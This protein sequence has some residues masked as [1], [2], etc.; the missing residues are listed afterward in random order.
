MADTN[1]YTSKQN[2]KKYTTQA[3]FDAMDKSD[4]PVGTEYNIVGEIEE[5]DLS[6]ELQTK[7]ASITGKQDVITNQTSLNAA[8]LSV[9]ALTVGTSG[10][11]V[12]GPLTVNGYS[13]LN[14]IFVDNSTTNPICFKRNN[15]IVTKMY[16]PTSG[17]GELVNVYLPGKAGTLA[18]TDDLT[19]KQDKLTMG[20]GL[21]I[22]GNV[23]YCNGSLTGVLLDVNNIK[24]SGQLDMSGTMVR[25][26]LTYNFPT[27][28]GTFALTSDI[29]TGS[30]GT[31]ITADGVVKTAMNASSTGGTG[32]LLMTDEYGETHCSTVYADVSG[33]HVAIT[34]AEKKTYSTELY[35][36]SICFSYDSAGY[37]IE[38]GH[39]VHLKGPSG[40]SWPLHADIY[41]PA[42]SGTVALLSDITGG[43][44]SAGVSSIDGKTGAILLGTGLT[45]GSNNVLSVTQTTNNARMYL[46]RIVG[47]F[48]RNDGSYKIM[49]SVY[50]G[51][52]TEFTGD[53]LN[54]LIQQLF[55]YQY[56]SVV[57]AKTDGS[58]PTGWDPTKFEQLYVG[59]IVDDVLYCNFN[60]MSMS[61]IQLYDI[62]FEM[63]IMEEIALPVS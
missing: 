31:T 55:E 38:D 4:V 32:V 40:G 60:E 50:N 25:G 36:D 8:A 16:G 57:I 2:I 42:K 56:T 63:D 11:T 45:I 35:P 53:T 49:I 12:S 26:G 39:Y 13:S 3:K 24:I 37:P 29:P 33:E 62:P 52:D 1:T 20:A 28:G 22:T 44:G 18:V 17:G 6:V 34:S 48:D 23:I 47:Y 54:N 9:N 27:K 43:G 21:S 58:S 59:T 19:G 7:I 30:G 46:H 10:A 15:S 14:G 51:A 61:S 5:A 41:L